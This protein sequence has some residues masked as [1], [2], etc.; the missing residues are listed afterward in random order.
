L[1][2]SSLMEMSLAPNAST[3]TPVWVFKVLNMS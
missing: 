3:L 1:L 2:P